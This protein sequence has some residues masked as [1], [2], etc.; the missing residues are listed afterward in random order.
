MIRVATGGQAVVVVLKKVEE[1]E[2]RRPNRH[3]RATMAALV[4]RMVVA[5]VEVLE[6]LVEQMAGQRAVMELCLQ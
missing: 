1:Q 6:K 3:L 2:T 5:A 4:L